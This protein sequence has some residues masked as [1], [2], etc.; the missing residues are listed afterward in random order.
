MVDLVILAGGRG[1]RLGGRDKAALEI[2]GS[3]L[4]SRILAGVGPAGTEPLGG[5]VVVVGETPVPDGILQTLEDPPDGG[6]VAGI[7]AGL[8]SL[9]AADVSGPGP[10]EW[11][12]VVAVDQPGAAK[13]LSVMRDLLPDLAEGVDALSQVDEEGHRQWLLACYRRSSLERALAALDSVR[14]ASVR[15]LVDGL[16]WHEV[17]AGEEYV[18]DEIGRAHV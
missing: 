5:R 6:P 10:H 7:A 12:A 16:T 1:E 18:G 2:G 8:D 9:P 17:R 4:L 11:V 13:A 14:E 15:R 3:S